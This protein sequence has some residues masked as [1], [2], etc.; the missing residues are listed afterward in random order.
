M[1]AKRRVL[2]VEDDAA[3][4][5]G[6][7][8][9]LRFGGYEPLG[10]STG[11]AGLDLALH[12]TFD[13]A[14][15]DVVLPGVSGLEILRAIR[16]ARPTTPVIMLTA[17]G[18][19]ND[20]VQGLSSGADDYV[21][22][23]FSVRELL[24]RLEAVL[25]RSPERPSDIGRMAIGAIEVDFDERV[26]TRPDETRE[27]LTEMEAG[28]LRYLAQNSAR[29]VARD[30][31]LSRVWG[32]DPK[33]VETRTVDMC[34]ARLREKLR[35]ATPDELIRTVRGVGYRFIEPRP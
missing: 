11:A 27:T 32:V 28:V 7:V 16:A 12:A 24:A 26:I 34:V 13:L 29:V 31:L 25:R 10:A 14:L 4:R 19:E 3:I 9:A 17:R 18:D 6:L 8:D 22:K 15:L 35:D 20:R 5:R 21:V 30:E 33:A 23:P 1:V 2:V